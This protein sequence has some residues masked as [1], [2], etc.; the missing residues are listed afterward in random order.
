MSKI[1][2]SS[3]TDL[4]KMGK[5]SYSVVYKVPAGGL[6]PNIQSPVVV[7]KYKKKVLEGNESAIEQY[8]RMLVEN[9]KNADAATKKV[10]DNYT[11]WPRVII[12]EGGEACGFAM[13]LI[14]EKFFVTYTG[15]SGNPITTSSTLG[16]VLNDD[17]TR[18][19]T[20]QPLLTVGGRA[21]IV[22]DLLMIMTHLHKYDFVVG[23]ISP[24]NVLVYVDP[25]AQKHNRV[26]LIDSDS[27]RKAN[28]THPMTQ[29]HTN[30]WYPPESLSA[31]REL[32]ALGGSGDLST[33]F[34]LQAREFLQN[35]QTD[36]YKICLAILR[37][38]HKGPQRTTILTSDQAMNSLRRELSPA[39]ADLIAKGLSETPSERPQMHLIYQ[40]LVAALR[41]KTGGSGK[42]PST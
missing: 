30:D 24:N 36:I 13:N 42:K 35:T 18:L 14:P 28:H 25:V 27:F 9:R 1:E 10:I 20:G 3:L 32:R 5:G 7:K 22:Y 34:R 39:F 29:P 16:F 17:D 8:L 33:T 15:A 23:D 19:R 2:F 37:L 31:M 12:Y 26:L 21:K 6:H 11:I 41:A 38:Y 40:A 4:E